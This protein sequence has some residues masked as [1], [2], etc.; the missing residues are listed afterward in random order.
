M[1][2][3]IG[4]Y[5]LIKLRRLEYGK[6][7]NST[8]HTCSRCINDSYFDSWSISWS[9]DAQSSLSEIKSN[10]NLTDNKISDIQ[11]W[12]DRKFEDKRIGWI[13]TFSDLETLEEY[14]NKFFSEDKDALVMSINFPEE[15]RKEFLQVFTKESDYG[16]IGIS[17]NLESPKLEN[18]DEEEIGYDLIGIEMGGDFHS[19]HCHDISEDLIEKFGIKLNEF[20]LIEN[21]NNWKEIVAYMNDEKNEFEPV[22]WFFVKVKKVKQ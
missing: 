12:A 20:G 19:F 10:F 11:N 18:Q 17:I 15:E 3:Y 5:Y 14:K 4:A 7:K 1:K 13:N 2:Y 8:I 16:E 21:T 9:N 22:P 6:I